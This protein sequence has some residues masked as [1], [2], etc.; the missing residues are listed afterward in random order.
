M[1]LYRTS[2][3]DLAATGFR[4]TD[5]VTVSGRPGEYSVLYLD[6]QNRSAR[7]CRIT[8]TGLPGK[9]VLTVPVTDLT[10]IARYGN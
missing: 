7:V 8:R 4:Q 1:G 10:L 3:E 9:H 5:T 2:A 6:R